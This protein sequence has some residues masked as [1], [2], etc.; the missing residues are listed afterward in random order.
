LQHAARPARRNGPSSGA[1]AACAARNLVAYAEHMWRKYGDVARFNIMGN[2]MVLLT[3]P[4]HIMRV[5]L[6]ER[7]NFV[8]GRSYDTPRTVMGD[9]L[10]TLEGSAWRGRRSLA[11]P[12][13]H[14]QALERLCAVMVESGHHYFEGMLARMGRDGM[15]VDA[16]VEMTHLTLDVVVSALFGKDAID[17]T[18]DV[19]FAALGSA[20]ELISSAF[21][22]LPIPRWI[23]TPNNLKFNRTMSQLDA[24]VYK[25]IAAG[26]AR[27]VSDGSLLSMLLDARNEEGAALPDKAVRDDVFTLFLAGHETTALTLT[28]LFVL[29]DGRP[30]VLRRME[31]E[32]AHVLGGRDPC[33]ADVPKLVYLR[34]VVD[35]TLRLRPPAALVG[36]NV[37]APSEFGGF[38]VDEKDTVLPFFWGVHRHPDFWSRPEAFDPDRFAPELAK[39]RNNWSYLPFSAGPRI[40][41]GNT[42]SLTE[43]VV[44]IAQMLNRFEI[45]VRSCADVRPQAVGTVRPSKPVR[46]G[47]KPRR[48]PE[49]IAVGRECAEARG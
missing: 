36:R 46:V 20:L 38:P 18:A 5:L 49:G 12:A 48:R 21:N 15:E 26:R 32:V 40:C 16:H 14:R 39:S 7:Q 8:K 29:L 19:S 30:D 33:F 28:W 41:I 45:D 34:Q 13:F 4:D 22:G 42:F 27:P 2:R 6:S 1:A 37:V 3:H 23:P 24:T 10:V 9:S 31:E 17:T 47:L 35:E 43:T 25:I 11:Q 44:L